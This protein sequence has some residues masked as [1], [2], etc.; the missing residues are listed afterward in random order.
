ME[1]KARATADGIVVLKWK[2]A[3]EV[4]NAGFNI[5]RARHKDGRYAQV[6]NAII[7]AKGG[8]SEASYRYEDTL[9]KGTFYYKLED[10]DTNGVSTT[11]GPVKV[12]VGSAGGEVRSRRR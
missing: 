11:H 7:S 5:H 2:T 1:F 4:N 10:V 6:N 3:S 9:G 12:R 8:T